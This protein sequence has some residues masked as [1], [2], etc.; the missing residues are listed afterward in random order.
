[1]SKHVTRAS[2]QDDVGVI[3]TQDQAD[4]IVDSYPEHERDAR[5][6]GIPMLGSG[7]IY[8]VADSDITIDPFEMPAYWP[9]IV[10]MDFGSTHPT[11]AVKLVWDRD[12]DVIYLTQTHRVSK[13]PVPIHAAA[14]KAWGDWLPIAWPH[15][16]DNET[17][18]GP[19]LKTQYLDAG[20]KMISHRAVYEDGNRSVE[21][22][23]QDIL[24]RMQTDRFKVFS[25][26]ADWLD[27]RRMYH[28]KDGKIVKEYDDLMDAT[29]YAVM[30]LRYAITKPRARDPA[31]RRPVSAMAA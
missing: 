3:Y 23:I 18:A 19:A 5:A 15:D 17:A 2:I 29:R 28:R 11:A 10:G 24:T 20:L 14:I 12:S 7:L 25:H 27:E 1:M 26:L 8:P 4:E 13:Q 9:Q 31:K 21:G 16:G 30:M 22:G 6:K